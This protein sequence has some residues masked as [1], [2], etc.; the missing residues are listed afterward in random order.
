MACDRQ[1]T[2][3]DVSKFKGKTKIFKVNSPKFEWPFLIGFSGNA[4]QFMQVLDFLES[5]EDERMPRVRGVTGLVLT[6]TKKIYTFGNTGDWIQIDQPYF[7]IGSGSLTAL[8]ALHAGAS[9]LEAVKAASK[10]D[11]FTGMGFRTLKF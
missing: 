11:P 7:S 3:A 9:P 1:F 10:V 6:A 8:G 2:Y 5:P 4:D